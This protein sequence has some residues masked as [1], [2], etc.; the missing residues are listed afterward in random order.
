MPKLLDN[1]RPQ[2]LSCLRVV[3]DLCGTITPWMGLQME[4]LTIL[5]SFSLQ[6]DTNR[7][8]DFLN[9]IHIKGDMLLPRVEIPFVLCCPKASP[10]FV[11]YTFQLTLQI[12]VTLSILE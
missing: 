8:L 2:S 10:S 4:Q 11:P 1:L 9:Q 3:L 7:L 6:V 12:E 5:S